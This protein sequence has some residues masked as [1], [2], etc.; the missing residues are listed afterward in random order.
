MI[1]IAIEL[2]AYRW[3]S[4]IR[5]RIQLRVQ[6]GAQLREAGTRNSSDPEVRCQIVAPDHDL[7]N[8]DPNSML[9]LPPLILAHPFCCLGANGERLCPK[10]GPNLPRV[11][12]LI[13]SECQSTGKMRRGVFD[14][15][16]TAVASN[17]S[18][19]SDDELEWKPQSLHAVEFAPQLL[20]SPTDWLS[21]EAT[22]SADVQRRL[23]QF[24]T[25]RRQGLARA[26]RIVPMGYKDT[27]LRENPESI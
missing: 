18:S 4:N 20:I 24:R 25:Y 11:R 9:Q 13:L 27:P 15:G 17:G 3:V 8:F 5:F 26:C 12:L 22:R 10:L 14:S 2:R 7:T 6:S 1:S 19:D 23:S 21:A 16:D